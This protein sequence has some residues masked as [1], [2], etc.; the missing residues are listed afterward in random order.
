MGAVKY[1]MKN[2]FVKLNMPRLVVT[3]ADWLAWFSY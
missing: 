2:Y 3:A 1:C